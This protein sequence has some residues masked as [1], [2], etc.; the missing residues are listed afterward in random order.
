MRIGMFINC[1]TP[2]KGGMETALINLTQGL[3]DAGHEVFIF[4]P[5]YPN[6]KETEANVYRYKFFSFV[7]K[8]FQYVIPYPFQYSMGKVVESLNLDIIHSHH[9]FLLGDDA[10]Y[11]SKKLHLPILLTYHTKYED[12][13]YY[14]PLLP[15][16][17]SQ[18]IIRKVVNNYCAKCH[19]II[20]PS[21]AIKNI[22]IEKQ[23]TTPV[24]VIPSG[25]DIENFARD[26]HQR[27]SVRSKYGISDKEIV[28]LTASRLAEEK[29]IT[30]LI[31]AFQLIS[32]QK[33]GVK[34]LILGDGNIRAELEQQVQQLGLGDKVI[35]T[36]MLNKNDMM[37]YYEAG[38]IFVF[39]SVTETQ[40]LV[41]VE[42]MASGLPIVAIKASGIEDMV[43]DQQDGFLTANNQQDFADKV[44]RLINDDRLRKQMS[45]Q[46]KENAY[47]FS[48][49]PWIARVT[50]LY[51]KLI[52]QNKNK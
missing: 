50:G 19:T 10:I 14:V 26:D 1:Y 22:I 36:G 38:D 24:E 17:L 20:A 46:A 39:A 33:S 35:F 44:L 18:W 25:I 8:N 3:K 49:K 29:N 11:Y 40:G 45:Q 32:Q 9:P 15:R 21:S 13:Y 7:Y 43:K 41:A 27:M 47:S 4:A 5:N 28:L 48:I 52:E 12:H 34:F 37:S 30:F 16:F 2:S 6:W 31:N 42:A 51:Q 23:I